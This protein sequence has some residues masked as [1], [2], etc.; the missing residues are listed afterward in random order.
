MFLICCWVRQE[1]FEG[2]QFALEGGGVGAE[3]V[4]GVVHLQIKINQLLSSANSDMLSQ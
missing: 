1:Y 3:A 2:L 4:A